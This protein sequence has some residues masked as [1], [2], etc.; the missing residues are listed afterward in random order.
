M[1]SYVPLHTF[2]VFVKRIIRV[3]PET[4]TH[5]MAVW[6]LGRELVL[7]VTGPRNLHNVGHL[8]LILTEI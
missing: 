2:T 8:K 1:S 6:E 4:E 7:P 5:T 3:S